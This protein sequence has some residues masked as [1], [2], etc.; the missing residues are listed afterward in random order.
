[1]EATGVF[2]APETRS[3]SFAAPCVKDAGKRGVA[4]NSVGAGA[5]DAE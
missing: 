5:A 2:E 1:M 3:S 4:E